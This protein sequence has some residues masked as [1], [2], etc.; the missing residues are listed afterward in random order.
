LGDGEVIGGILP[1]I[2]G[3]FFVFNVREGWFGWFAGFSTSETE[4]ENGNE[5]AFYGNRVLLRP[6]NLVI[7]ESEITKQ[8]LAKRTTTQ[9]LGPCTSHN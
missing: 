7:G 8:V 4:E 1:P 3:Q 6:I 9:A 2:A 5:K